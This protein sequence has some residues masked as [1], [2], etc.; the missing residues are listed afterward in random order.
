MGITNKKTV[1]FRENKSFD[2]MFSHFF[3]GHKKQFLDSSTNK[4]VLGLKNDLV[5]FNGEY[6]LEYLDRCSLFC[7]NMVFSG[8]ILFFISLVEAY[9]KLTLFFAVRCCQKFYVN[10]WFGGLITNNLFLNDTSYAFILPNLKNANYVLRESSIKLI[11]TICIEDSDNCFHKGFYQLFGNDDKKD[12]IHLFYNTLSDS[13][14]KSL[15]FTYAKQLNSI[16]LY[17]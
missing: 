7:S 12:S 11:P 5:V 6:F 8:G 10:K 4:Y 14:I 1:S 2:F 16:S 17:Q 3:W 9:E 15:L 13:V